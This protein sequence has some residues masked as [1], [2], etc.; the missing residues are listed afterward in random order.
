MSMNEILTKESIYQ[1]DL[2]IFWK[3]FRPK[4]AH[5]WKEIV[6]QDPCSYCGGTFK[7]NIMS[8]E[9]IIPSKDG[10]SKRWDNIVGACRVCNTMRNTTPLLFIIVQPHKALK[11]RWTK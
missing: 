5:S 1:E 7:T 3:I 10:G 8:I 11:V 6:Y 4:Q 9:H 2:N